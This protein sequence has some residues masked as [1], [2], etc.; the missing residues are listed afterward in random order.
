MLPEVESG[1]LMTPMIRESETDSLLP[2]YRGKAKDIS[3]MSMLGID[4]PTN[5]IEDN[6]P[7]IESL[8]EALADVHASL[9]S[10]SDIDDPRKDE[11][12]HISATFSG[13]ERFISFYLS[14]DSDILR[15]LGHEEPQ[16]YMVLNQNRDE[17]RANGG[18]PG[19]VITFTLYK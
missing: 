19:S 5:W 16:R 3:P 7:A 12:M 10:I 17:I 14:H 11:I 9:E 8:R 15:M 18:F 6:E 4:D 2:T 1:T 13:L